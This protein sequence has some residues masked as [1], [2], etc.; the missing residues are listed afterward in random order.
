[1]EQMTG[2]HFVERNDDILKEDNVLLSEWNSKARN[3]A[4]QDI[5]QFGSSIEFKCFMN[6]RIK[7]IVNGLSNHLSSR[8]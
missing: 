7:A 5:K 1:M 6:Q 3:N 2:L 8:H 4:C